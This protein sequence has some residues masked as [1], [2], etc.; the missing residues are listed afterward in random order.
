MERSKLKYITR[1]LKTLQCIQTKTFHSVIL[2]HIIFS[3]S[4]RLYKHV[5][6][7]TIYLVL[8]YYKE[9]SCQQKYLKRNQKRKTTM[10][11]NTKQNSL[12]KKCFIVSILIKNKSLSPDNSKTHLCNYLKIKL[13]TCR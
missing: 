6:L 5:Y 4:K 13:L 9:F 1:N 3:N 10:I 2:L 7:S 11:P 12:K 8:L